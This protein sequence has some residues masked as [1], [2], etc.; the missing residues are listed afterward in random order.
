VIQVGFMALCHPWA[1][2]MRLLSA[3]LIA[4]APLPALAQAAPAPEAAPPAAPAPETA[5]PPKS[6]G[7]LKGDAQAATYE[8]GEISAAADGAF[9]EAT[10]GVAMVIQKIFADLGKPNAYIVGREGGGALIVG[11]RYGRGKL[12]SKVEGEREIFWTG[13]SIGPDVGGDAS[14]SFVLVYNLHDSE[15]I[16]QRFA[17]V[18]G[19]GQLSPAW[20]YRAGADP[21]G[22]RLAARR[23]PGIYQVQPRGPGDPLLMPVVRLERRNA[24]A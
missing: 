11:L 13:P 14:R 9:G 10:E 18:E 1:M 23:E 12:F 22:G 15:E 4:A 21:A 20:R 19:I 6:D 17:A 8:I 3:L 16:F 5:A 7:S 24:A 2:T